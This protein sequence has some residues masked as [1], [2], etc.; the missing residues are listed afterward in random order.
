MATKDKDTAEEIEPVPAD[1]IDGR[2]D[3]FDNSAASVSALGLTP[4]APDP[5]AIPA[6]LIDT[7]TG[8]LRRDHLTLSDAEAVANAIG[9]TVEA[10]G[11][12]FH[13]TDPA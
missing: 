13:V 4:D 8:E 12:A 10:I 6:H 5:D 7:A 11:V 2:P 9:G 3:D 1:V